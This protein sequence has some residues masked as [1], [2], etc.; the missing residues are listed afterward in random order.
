MIK[1][2]A[3]V[4]LTL[5]RGNA[6]IAVASGSN[7]TDKI[8]F[9]WRNDQDAQCEQPKE[10]Y[11]EIDNTRVRYVEAGTGPAVVM[12]HGNAGSVDDFDF[13]NFAALCREH[14]LIAVDRPGHG[15]SDRPQSSKST[16]QFQ[17][18]LLHDALSRLGV[19]RPVIVGH[20][21]GGAL[22][23][24]YALDYPNE[25]SAIVLLA[26]AAYPDGG[27]DQ[28]LR[29]VIEAPVIGDVSLTV[30]RLVLGKHLLKKELSKAFYP[31]TVPAEYLRHA[32]SEWLGH[33]QVRAFIHDE[34]SLNK[35]L[36]KI[37]KHYS[38]IRIPVVIVTGDQDR[39]VSA[40]D[41]A[42]HLKTSIAQSQLIELKNTGH[43]IPQTHPES[44]YSAINS[45]QKSSARLGDARRDGEL[46]FRCHLPQSLLP[47]RQ[48]SAAQ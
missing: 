1:V 23:L 39:V 15:K 42:Y 10:A 44:I 13:K 4:L 22:A 9:F 3:L 41:N 6:V 36:E 11:L 30:G 7:S 14:R 2:Y 20:S 19:I 16:L 43:Q 37:S 8:P 35:D 21:W 27:G 34:Y 24:D 17:T 18:K 46:N 40:K 31:E 32:S 48:S 28:F 33:K 45:I 38:E 12:I 29:K 47:M 5:L 25:V 26:P